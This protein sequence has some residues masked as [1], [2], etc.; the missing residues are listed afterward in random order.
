MRIKETPDPATLS[1]AD[2]AVV[3]GIS[4]ASAYRMA[5]RY[6]QTQGAEGIPVIRFGRRLVVPTARLEALLTTGLPAQ[7]SLTTNK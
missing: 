3:L 6:E 1:L 5:R 7:A 2:A 4:K